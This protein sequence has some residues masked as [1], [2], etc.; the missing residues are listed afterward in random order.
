MLMTKERKQ[1]IN[2]RLRDDF[3]IKKLKINNIEENMK[4]N[5]DSTVYILN[6][7]GKR[8]IARGQFMDGQFVV[9]PGSLISE[10][11]TEKSEKARGA[12]RDLTGTFINSLGLRE[13]GRLYSFS[14]PSAAL[15]FC[16]GY[17]DN[18]WI[19]WKTMEGVSLRDV[20]PELY[21][22]RKYLRK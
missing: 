13:T 12:A 9:L 10:T 8:T 6:C 1:L 14:N 21:E 18:G 15:Q 22:K 11:E 17:V 16:A 2:D 19:K 4:A 3:H 20:R 7:P 5:N